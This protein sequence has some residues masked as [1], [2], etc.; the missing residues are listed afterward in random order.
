[1]ADTRDDRLRTYYQSGDIWEQEIVKKVKR[2][3]A[4][5]WSVAA[6]FAGIAFVSL[7]TVAARAPEELRTLYR[8]GGQEHWVY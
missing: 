7:T 3:R 4:L 1:M 2:S 5:A 6:I 8:R